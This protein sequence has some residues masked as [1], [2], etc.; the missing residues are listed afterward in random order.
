MD[1]RKICLLIGGRNSER[2]FALPGEA[3]VVPALRRGLQTTII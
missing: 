3:Q 2:N 1:E